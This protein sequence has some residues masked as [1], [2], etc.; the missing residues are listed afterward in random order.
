MKL[1]ALSASVLPAAL[2]PSAMLAQSS[3]TSPI[4]GIWQGVATV[5]ET[6]QFPIT[7]RISGN[8]ST[9]KAEFLNGP[10]DHPD[11][12]PA[13][14]VTFDGTNLIASF[15]YFARTLDATLTDGKLAGTTDQL[16]EKIPQGVNLN[17]WPTSFFVGR[18]RLV[19]ET[20]A[21][22]AG[23]R[24]TVGHTALKHDVTAL[25]EKLLAEPASSQ[26]VSGTT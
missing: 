16:A 26:T 3:S 25:V 2:T 11:A 9:L 1:L 24:N 7:I 14:S 4:V 8:G 20:H 19:R 17:C 10:A 18:D 5:R 6:Q 13:S 15:D 12:T 23:P 22:F 21:G